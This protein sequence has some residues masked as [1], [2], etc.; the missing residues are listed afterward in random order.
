MER[1]VKSLGKFMQWVVGD[2]EK[3]ERREIEGE[4]VEWKP[5]KKEVERRVRMWYLRKVEG[6]HNGNE[7]ET[8][9][10]AS[11]KKKPKQ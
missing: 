6:K 9:E 5:V 1:G 2:V 11:G 3:E 8:T 7:V 4:G 10:D